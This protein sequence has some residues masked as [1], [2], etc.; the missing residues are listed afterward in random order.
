MDNPLRRHS[1]VPLVVPLPRDRSR[2]LGAADEHEKTMD[3]R[4]LG[5]HASFGGRELLMVM[6]VSRMIIVISLAR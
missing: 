2:R 6:L 4:A 3:E 1:A 5:A